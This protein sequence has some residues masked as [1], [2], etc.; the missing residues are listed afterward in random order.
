MSDFEEFSPLLSFCD[1]HHD[2]LIDGLNEF[3]PAGAGIKCK[4]FLWS[5]QNLPKYF[6]PMTDGP[7]VELR[8]EPGD[9]HGWYLY[10]LDSTKE[11]SK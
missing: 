10:V 11:D 2:K 1:M 5:R 6:V 7:P 3:G 9:A 8:R 4:A